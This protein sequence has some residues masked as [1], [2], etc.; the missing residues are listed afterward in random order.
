M[1]PKQYRSASDLLH[2]LPPGWRSADTYLWSR[3]RPSRFVE[4]APSRLD[5]TANV[6]L[7]MKSVRPSY[8]QDYDFISV[9]AP[10]LALLSRCGSRKVLNH[11][12]GEVFLLYH[13][14]NLVP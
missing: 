10:V 13:G 1:E 6:F 7:Q 5:Y 3:W 8:P 12:C 9:E 11:P 2:S 4:K 14:I